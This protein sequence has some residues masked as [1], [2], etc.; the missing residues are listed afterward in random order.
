MPKVAPI[1][2][3]RLHPLADWCWGILRALGIC[4][5]QV[6]SDKAFQ[7]AQSVKNMTAIREAWAQS[8]GQEDPLEKGMATHSSILA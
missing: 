6:Y 1:L 7:V 2:Q 5:K 8:L 3:D 4:L